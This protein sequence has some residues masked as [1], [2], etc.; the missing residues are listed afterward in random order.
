MQFCR[1]NQ[2]VCVTLF[3]Y[4]LHRI[5]FGPPKFF[6]KTF[7]FSIL[8][9][10]TLQI[11]GGGTFE[12]HAD[13]DKKNRNR[14]KSRSNSRNLLKPLLR[15]RKAENLY[16][17]CAINNARRILSK[18]ST[19]LRGY[20]FWPKKLPPFTHRPPS[21]NGAFK[22]KRVTGAAIRR[23]RTR[24]GGYTQRAVYAQALLQVRRGGRT[25]SNMSCDTNVSDTNVSDTNVSKLLV[26]GAFDTSIRCL[27]HQLLWCMPLL[28]LH[29]CWLR[30][31]YTAIL[32]KYMYACA[33]R[34]KSPLRAL[35]FSLLPRQM[36]LPPHALRAR[37]SSPRLIAHTPALCVMPSVFGGCYCG[38]CGNT[39]TIPSE[40][41]NFSECLA[42]N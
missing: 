8:F 38:M 31:I 40:K 42:P 14:R 17:H 37:M 19:F 1:T 23:R 41:N 39:L 27:L 16:G 13:P 32:A 12:K 18:G 36:P 4:P 9:C 2:T 30:T 3:Y 20:W 7:K 5:G 10:S 22:T 29:V 21:E 34:R 6:S 24:G 33:Y 35:M 28:P 11:S 15:S 26:R 25:K